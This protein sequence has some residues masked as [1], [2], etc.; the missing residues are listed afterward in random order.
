[1]CGLREVCA[2]KNVNSIKNGQ[3]EAIINFIMGNRPIGKTV[4]DS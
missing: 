4:P 3:I 1:M 2:L